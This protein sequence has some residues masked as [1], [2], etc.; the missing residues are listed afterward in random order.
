MV[1]GTRYVKSKYRMHLI[2]NEVMKILLLGGTGFVGR[3]ITIAALAANHTVTCLN[4]NVTAPDLFPEVEQLSAD[5]N[6]DL[7]CLK[8][9]QWDV[10]VDC[11]G[12]LPEWLEASCR[13]LRNKVGHYIFVSTGSVYDSCSGESDIDEKATVVST[14]NLGQEYWGADY[15][16]LKI[17]C[18]NCVK[19]HFPENSTVLRLGV[20]AGPYDPT[21]RVTYWVDRIARGGDIIIPCQPGSSLRFVD[22]RDLADFTLKMAEEKMFGTYN[23]GGV[24]LTW[25]HWAKA[26][27]TVNSCSHKI[28]WLDRA[29][30]AGW[31]EGDKTRPFGAFPM[32]PGRV[33]STPRQYNSSK[34]ELA[35]LNY[36]PPENT[37]R[38]IQSW[39]ET[40][41]IVALKDYPKGCSASVRAAL[42]WGAAP[43]MH[44]WMAGLSVRDEKSLLSFCKDNQLLPPRPP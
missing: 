38:D 18:E 2:K 7:D 33:S 10:V 43:E 12:Y 3:H 11:N 36:R 42:D 20:V 35:G 21:D 17:L 37:A 6:H 34:A 28:H 22:A 16:G 41:S 9:R 32:I 44:Q 14:K 29:D 30:L 40:R 5:R 26:C 4:R 31:E 39:N 15:G 27:Q 1:S 19:N 23:V 8:G 13:L 25:R 24:Q